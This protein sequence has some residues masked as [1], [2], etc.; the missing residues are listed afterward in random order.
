MYIIY[1][2][3]DY[4]SKIDLDKKY[5]SDLQ[6]LDKTYFNEIENPKTYLIKKAEYRVKRYDLVNQIMTVKK[7]IEDYE[8]HYKHVFLPTYEL[9]LE[10]TKNNWDVF[11]KQAQES[12]NADIKN[13]LEFYK[14]H[15]QDIEIKNMVYQKVRAIN[16]FSTN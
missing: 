10:E 1:P 8:N 2:K 15:M 16:D 13:V 9:Q 4:Q 3:K 14:D 7:M 6:E 12:N 11:I 5:L